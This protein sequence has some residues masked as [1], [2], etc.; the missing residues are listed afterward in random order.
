MGGLLEVRNLTPH[1]V[2]VVVEGR[3]VRLEPVPD[4][5]RVVEQ[6]A[7][8]GS[9]LCGGVAVPVVEVRPAEVAGLPPETPGVWLVVARAV[10]TAAPERADLLVPFD[11]VRDEHGAVIGCRG[12]ARLLLSVGGD[13]GAAAG[14]C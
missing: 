14:G 4:P 10:A 3:E 7:A 12:F 8:A 11:A 1:V 5:P 13:V 9:V 6:V 2:L